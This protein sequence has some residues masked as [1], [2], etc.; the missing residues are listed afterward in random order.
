MYATL[1]FSALLAFAVPP[2]AKILVDCAVRAK[3]Y[4]ECQIACDTCYRHCTWKV[5]TGTKEHGLAMECCLS[6]ADAC[7]LAATLSA[8]NSPL[9]HHASECC[10]KCCADAA[11]ACDLF[12]NDEAMRRC[13][14]ACRACEKACKPLDVKK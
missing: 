4:T 7:R 8:R 5:L 2:D 13:A 9:A 11:K 10:R 3:A 14:E 6:C 1:Y 12:P